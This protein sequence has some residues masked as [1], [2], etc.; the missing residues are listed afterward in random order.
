M[1]FL[2]TG[3]LLWPALI[4]YIELSSII[5][6]RFSH[7]KK[8]KE[9]R[10]G[11]LFIDLCCIFLHNIQGYTAHSTYT[12]V[13]IA[14]H[15]QYKRSQQK[16]V[17]YQHVKGVIINYVATFLHKIH[18]ISQDEGQK[19]SFSSFLIPQFTINFVGCFKTQFMRY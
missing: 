4:W 2:S 9:W 6:W 3:F 1:F 19:Y 16:M 8:A 7:G 10:K 14:L 13:A 17:P 15:L 18:T 5:K 12:H 11:K